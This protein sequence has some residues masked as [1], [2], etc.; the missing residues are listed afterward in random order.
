MSTEGF[1]KRSVLLPLRPDVLLL[2]EPTNHLDLES[3]LGLFG[4]TKERRSQVTPEILL[5]VQKS[6]EKPTWDV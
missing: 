5:M 6:G 3:V 1:A 4:N 2:D